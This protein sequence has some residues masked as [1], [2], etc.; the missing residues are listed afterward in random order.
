[1]REKSRHK[2]FS[3]FKT[4]LRL[5]SINAVKHTFRSQTLGGKM[6]TVT[7]YTAILS[8]YSWNGINVAGKAAFVSYSFETA[9]HA[10]DSA[11]VQATFRPFTEGEK[12]V[13]RGAFQIWDNA[14]GI[15]F[16]EVARGQGDIRLQYIDF[17]KIPGIS[18]FAGYA[19]YPSTSLISGNDYSDANSLSLNTK[20]Q[21]Y[22]VAAKT[23]LILHEI[24]HAIGLK[25]TFDGNIVLNSAIDNKTYSIMSY[26]GS[27]STLGSL[28][29]QAVQYLY[30]SANSDGSQV[31][32]W[33]W[34]AQDKIL[35]QTGRDTAETIRG[36]GGTDNIDAGGGDDVV[37]GFVGND[38]LFG[39]TGN[40]SLFGGE[41]DDRISGGLGN[42]LLSGNDFSVQ[43]SNITTN[44][45]D[46]VDYSTSASAVIV[47]LRPVFD[48]AT[49]SY[50]G[51]ASGADIGSD[52]LIDIGGAMGGSAADS[53]T[54]NQLDNVF[55]G[56]GGNDTIG[57][58][59]GI[60]TLDGGIGNDTLNGGDGNDDLVGG[61]G[62][63]A[64][65]GGAGGDLLDGGAGVDIARYDDASSGI[66]AGLSGWTNFGEAAGDTFINVEG[67]YATNY[68][69]ILG[70]DAKANSFYGLAGDDGIWGY[71]GNDTLNGGDGNDNL[72]GGTGGDVLD[73][74]NGWDTASYSEASGGIVAGLA[75][76]TNFGEAAGDTFLAIEG[77]YA[78]N[79]GDFLGGDGNSNALY[80]RGGDDSLWGYGGNDFLY[81]GDGN[82]VL[83]G[84]A[85]ADLLDGGAG[86]DTARYDEASA[87]VVVGLS[88]WT[89]FGE[90]AGDTFTGIESIFASNF[91][92]YL[93]GDG[94]SNALYG[95]GGDD[96]LYGYGGVDYLYGGRGNDVLA[97]GA[98]ADLFQW[99]SGDGNDFITDFDVNSGDVLQLLGTSFTSFAQVQ[100]AL[101]QTS[102]VTQTELRIGTE[103]LYLWGVTP[104]QFTANDFLFV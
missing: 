42:D 64:L 56:N 86:W 95:R 62:D 14:S 30:G 6:A 28:D 5:F 41:G 3:N 21:Y 29:P 80:G 66:V 59:G 88:G 84:G 72:F 96:W 35:T 104:G 40:D 8:G 24:G 76:W 46:L 90:A 100:A 89:N 69:D 7:D 83:Y 81:A 91:T 79:F 39:G 54:G 53:L 16:V 77:I 43:Y 70:G 101:T 71:G 47:D 32:S 33:S 19:S 9:P 49:S 48:V 78:T 68:G 99:T 22:S 103:T 2:N 94:N 45:N 38:K 60:D 50:T 93:G 52:K 75:G 17:D 27:S 97:G 92:D 57:G 34:S 26:T 82:D 55:Y 37:F 85:G 36:I 74:G 98:G 102:G 1:M 11:A 87:G 31:A 44:P 63:D 51:V 4:R 13:A 25:H 65:D 23:G 12:E 15:K 10:E 58:Q 73:G 67:I 20:K 61:D 18:G